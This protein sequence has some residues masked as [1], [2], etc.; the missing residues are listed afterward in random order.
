MTTTVKQA[1]PACQKAVK[2]PVFGSESCNRYNGTTDA[3]T[4]SKIPVSIQDQKREGR[5]YTFLMVSKYSCG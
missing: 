1:A 2:T 4:D 5:K 3:I